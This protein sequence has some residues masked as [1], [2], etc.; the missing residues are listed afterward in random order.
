VR[1]GGLDEAQFEQLAA[2]LAEPAPDARVPTIHPPPIWSTTPM[3]ELTALG[4]PQRLAAA[5]GGS[6]VRLV[7]HGNPSR[8]RRNARRRPRVVSPSTGGHAD[9]LAH[10]R[11]RAGGC[12][13]VDVLDDGEIVV[14]FVQLTGREQIPHGD[15][16]DEPELRSA[17]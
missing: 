6:D 13:G 1:L 5:I 2:E 15:R 10:D 16:R 9:V 14:T 12:A 17:V 8:Q 11:S 4:G 3:S 7:L